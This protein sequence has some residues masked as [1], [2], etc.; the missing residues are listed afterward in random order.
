M[1]EL[2][3]SK[4]AYHDITVCDEDG[5]LALR[6]SGRRQSSVDAATGLEAR[7]PIIDYLHL[8]LALNPAAM[9]VLAIGL[10]GGVLPKRMWHDYPEMR[11]DVVELD[12]AVVDVARR[13]FA[14]PDDER[15]RVIV[16]DGRAYLAGT[17]E[18]YDL[19]IVDAYFEACAPFA[20]ATQEFVALAAGR[21]NPGGVLAYNMV[22]VLAG[23]GSR[24]LHRFVKGIAAVLPAVY[25]FPVGVGC[26][27][28]R[29]NIMVMATAESVPADELRRRIRNRVDGRVTVAGFETFADHLLDDPLPTRGVRPLA[30]A[31][32]PEDGLLR[33]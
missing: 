16:G 25:V 21:L 17:D 23:R 31:E 7:Q 1:K 10:G 11:I 29:Q 33:A 5:V 24:M 19:I 28:R 4:S 20:L 18:R 22:G 8:P 15:L 27:G 9:R 12:P 3:H 13:F 14:L 32:T 2:Y 6:F 26:G 30:D